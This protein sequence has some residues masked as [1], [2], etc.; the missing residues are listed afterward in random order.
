MTAGER[1]GSLSQ[2]VS[3]DL[4]LQVRQERGW[5]G[6]ADTSTT[7]RNSSRL[8]LNM[9]NASAHEMPLLVLLANASNES[10]Y[11][12]AMRNRPATGAAHVTVYGAGLGLTSLSVA[13]RLGASACQETHWFSDTTVRC[14]SSDGRASS[15]RISVTNQAQ[16]A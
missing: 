9:T 6:S 5:N 11:S 15:R 1:A 14:R 7:T 12:I 8:L 10:L 13:S 4:Y 2:A 3:F 16:S